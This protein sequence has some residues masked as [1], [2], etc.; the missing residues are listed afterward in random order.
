MNKCYLKMTLRSHTLFGSGQ[1]FGAVVDSD[2]VFDEIGIPYIPAKRVKG[3]LLDAATEVFTMFRKARLTFPP[4]IG[5]DAADDKA[6][7]AYYEKLQGEVF[8]KGG[9]QSG[10]AYFANLTVDKYGANRDWLRYLS[11]PKQKYTHILSKETMMNAFTTIRQQTAICEETGVAKDQSLRTVR[12]ARK[13]LVFYGEIGIRS[14][15]SRIR[16]VLALACHN[17][18]HIGTSRNRGFGEVK[19]RLLNEH[20]EPVRILDQLEGLCTQ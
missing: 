6:R 13:G 8:G 7:K 3:C 1:G 19:C 10:A 12:V 2:I 17:L 4:R 14:D 9:E 11:D 18:R 5:G 15:E 16:D 20:R